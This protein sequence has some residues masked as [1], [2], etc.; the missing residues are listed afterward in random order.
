MGA[1]AGAPR[2]DQSGPL[3]RAVPRRVPAVPRRRHRGAATAARERRHHHR[4]RRGVGG[5]AGAEARRAGRATPA[6][7]ATSTPAPAAPVH[8]PRGRAPRLPAQGQRSDG[9]PDRHHPQPRRPGRRRRATRSPCGSPRPRSGLGSRRPGRA[10]RA[11]TPDGRGGST[12]RCR[13]RRCASGGRC[14]PR[15]QALVDDQMYDRPADPT[16]GESGCTGWRGRSPTWPGVDGPGVAEVEVALRL[17]SG[18]PAAGRDRTRTGG[19]MS[20]DRERL[21]RVALSQLGEPGDCGSSRLVAELGADRLYAELLERPRL[22]A[23]CATT[24]PAGSAASSPSATSSAQRR[25]AIR[26]VVPGDAEWPP[27]STTST[28]AEPLQGRAGYRSDC[29]S[30][31][32]C[33]STSWPRRWPWSGPARRRPTAPTSRPSSR[34]GWPGRSRGGLRRGVR[35]RPGRPS[36]R[37]G[38]RGATV[39]VLA[40]GVDRAYPVAHRPLL[41]HL[42]THGAVVSEA[43]PGLCP[44]PVAVPVAQPGD[45]GADPGHGRG[46]GGGR[47]AAPSTPP[48]GPAGSTAPLM[49]VPGP[50]TSATSEGVHQLIRSGA[51][52]LVTAGRRRAGAG[53]RRPVSTS[54]RPPRGPE[55]PRDRLTKRA[56]AGPRGGPGS[57]R[58]RADSIARTAGLGLKEV[59]AR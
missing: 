40:C 21:A 31:A 33:G 32:R 11:A 50:V 39:A 36:R 16:R 57:R 2:R 25:L 14:R 10:R 37:A 54:W 53:R 22:P 12:A 13:A 28:V 43:A 1:A 20:A 38:G 9:R 18:R 51:A 41:D 49:G 55:R 7:A 29:G 47:A 59:H 8:V 4:P 56:A 45:R 58:R 3:R 30:G 19:R 17:R 42:A 23:S 35:H 26:F 15:P 46:G 6:R 34:P 48:T 44:D 27:S 24:W 52:T 5:A